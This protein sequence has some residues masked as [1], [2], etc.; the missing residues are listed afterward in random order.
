MLRNITYG[1]Y[2]LFGVL[3]FLGAAFIWF[4]VPETKRVS[5]EEMD[6]LFGSEGN[7]KIGSQWPSYLLLLTGCH[8][9]GTAQADF[10]R[11]EEIN[12]E[13][14]LAGV[15]G[16]LNNGTTKHE[17]SKELNVWSRMLDMRLEY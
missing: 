7:A 13:I 17:G 10:E 2:I 16:R 5:L 1:T 6:V 14:G 15:L 4:F 11:M 9:L 3:T 12:V 8:Y